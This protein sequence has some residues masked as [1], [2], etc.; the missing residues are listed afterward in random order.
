MDFGYLSIFIFKKVVSFMVIEFAKI[1]KTLG[2]C[3]DYS[4]FFIS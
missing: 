2:P 1:K 3:S 4:R